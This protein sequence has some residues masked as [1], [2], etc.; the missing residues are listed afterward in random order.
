MTLPPG[1][2]KHAEQFA[3]QADAAPAQDDRNGDV[4]GAALLGWLIAGDRDTTPAGGIDGD[5]RGPARVV[6]SRENSRSP[7]VTCG[8]PPRNRR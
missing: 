3:G 8:R 5:Q 4:R 1:L 2:G 6:D 7:D